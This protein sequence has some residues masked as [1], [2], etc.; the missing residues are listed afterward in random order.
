[1][2]DVHFGKGPRDDTE[3]KWGESRL[4]DLGFVESIKGNVKQYYFDGEDFGVLADPREKE[5]I[6]FRVY[7]KPFPKRPR[8]SS[9]ATLR[10]FSLRD[11]WKHDIIG[12]FKARLASVGA[13][14]RQLAAYNT[15]VE[16]TVRR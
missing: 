14:P 4:S 6:S 8:R 2:D 16:V 12:K 15:S 7:K 3:M 5:Q 9:I 13:C 10:T 11:S 1:M